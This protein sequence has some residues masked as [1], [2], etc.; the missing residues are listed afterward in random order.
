MSQQVSLKLQS[1]EEASENVKF[2]DIIDQ[3]GGNGKFQLRHNIIF[4][5]LS[6]TFLSMTIYG[7]MLA[8][9]VPDHWCF[10]PGIEKANVSVDTWKDMTIPRNGKTYSACLMYKS[11]GEKNE[12]IPCMYGWEYDDSWFSLTA[13]SQENWVCD[14]AVYVHTSISMALL[15][16]TFFGVAFFYFGDRFGRRKQYIFCMCLAIIF[17]GMQPFT[18]SIFPLFVTASAIASAASMP[19]AES[20]LAIGIELCGIR[21][22][23]ANNF[24]LSLCFAMG[25]ISIILIAWILR[26]WVYFMLVAAVLCAIPLF[27]IRY[28]PESPRWCVAKGHP[29]RALKVLRGV[30]TTNGRVLPDDT[31]I[32]LKNLS[33][34]TTGKLSL[35][36]IFLNK[37]LLK[38]TLL[39]IWSRTASGLITLTL[40]LSTKAF[41]GNPFVPFIGQAAL[42]I[43][44]ISM[45]HYVG[46]KFGRR[47][48]HSFT[49]LTAAILLY[50]IICLITASSPQ[51]MVT[52]STLAVQFCA[53]AS[54]SFTNLQSL[55]IHPT[56]VR[57]T[58]VA[59]EYMLMNAV[60]CVAPYIAFVG[61]EIE[62]RYMFGILGTIMLIT[63]LLISFLPESL[64]KIL[65]ETLVDV[66]TFGQSQK[67]W[68]FFPKGMLGSRKA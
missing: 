44:A 8:I 65:P 57:Q 55:E 13:A 47:C 42:H 18:A 56:C 41:G 19:A 28:L 23:S 37:I 16:S 53:Q 58:S 30:A 7:K 20:V 26:N 22:R 17:R 34:Q 45:S 51:W 40:L 5:C 60:I 2:E 64:N 10:V 61:A 54:V 59:M 1:S 4:I 38:N 3:I 27:F 62:S 67:Y 25:T 43:P 14:K 49:V 15:F 39:L 66:S 21:H 12:T 35:K 46:N 24:R 11:P 68:I 31:L 63:S 36:T 52:A 9:T 29:E 6:A 48:S 33:K 32:K 50:L